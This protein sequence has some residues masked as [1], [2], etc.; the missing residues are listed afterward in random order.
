M[1]LEGDTAVSSIA[2]LHGKDTTHS[3]SHTVCYELYK[4]QFS[5][6]E[7]NKSHRMHVLSHN[8]GKWSA[9]YLVLFS[10]S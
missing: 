6:L 3:I 9:D 8:N 7:C 10:S 5:K 2:Y 1:Q 4:K